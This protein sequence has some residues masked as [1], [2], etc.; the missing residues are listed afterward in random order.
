MTQTDLPLADLAQLARH[1]MVEQA[2]DDAIRDIR[3][4]AAQAS[5]HI[6]RRAGQTWR[7]ILERMERPT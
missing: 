4:M 5:A 1:A 3:A 7:R 2:G 6:N